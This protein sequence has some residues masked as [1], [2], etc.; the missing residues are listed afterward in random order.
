MTCP[1]PLQY[2][3]NSTM[4]KFPVTHV[5]DGVGAGIC[6]LDLVGNLGLEEPVA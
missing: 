1:P 5:G 4:R 2:I 6:G 3:I